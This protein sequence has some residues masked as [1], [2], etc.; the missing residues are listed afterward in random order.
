MSNLTQNLL[1]TYYGFGKKTEIG[2]TLSTHECVKIMDDEINISLVDE[3][4]ENEE[5]LTIEDSKVKTI[6]KNKNKKIFLNK[7]LNKYS[8]TSI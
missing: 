7:Y 1:S 2:K 6:L 4:F 3:S 8:K 5:P